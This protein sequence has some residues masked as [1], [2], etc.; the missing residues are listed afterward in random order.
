[1]SNKQYFNTFVCLWDSYPTPTRQQSLTGSLYRNIEKLLGSCLHQ[2]SIR[3]L[4]CWCIMLLIFS[5]QAQGDNSYKHTKSNCFVGE[6]WA[7]RSVGDVQEVNKTFGHI[8][9][10]CQCVRPW[11]CRQTLLSPLLLSFPISNLYYKSL[12]WSNYEG[13]KGES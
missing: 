10:D 4:A 9:N 1:M 3:F 2:T 12:Q 8:L 11:V 13:N 6:L 5:F 7:G